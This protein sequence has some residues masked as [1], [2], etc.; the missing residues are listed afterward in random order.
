MNN[1]LYLR[2]ITGYLVSALEDSPCTFDLDLMDSY[3][4]STMLDTLQDH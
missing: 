4:I 3:K 1:T 2:L